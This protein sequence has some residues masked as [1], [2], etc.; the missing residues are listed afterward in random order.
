MRSFIGVEAKRKSAWRV[1]GMLLLVAAL[2][3]LNG[4]CS[5][6]PST[7]TPPEIMYFGS[8]ATSG[9]SLDGSTVSGTITVYVDARNSYTSAAFFVD[10]V[11]MKGSPA[12]VDNASPYQMVLDTTTLADGTNTLTVDVTIGNGGNKTKVVTQASF[13]VS[14]TGSGTNAAPVVDAGPDRSIVLGA[15]VSLDGKVS[16]DGLPSGQ[17]TVTWSKVTGP[18]SVAFADAASAATTATFSA[19]GTYTLRLT[20]DD[21][22]LTGTD[23]VVVTVSA[24]TT[25]G[26][27][28][29]TRVQT[30]FYPWYGTPSVDG[31]WIHWEQNGHSPPDDIASQ[32]YPASG[33]YSDGDSATL[34]QQMKWMADAGIGVAIESWWGQGSLEDQRTPAVLAAAAANGVKVAFHIEPYAGRTPTSVEADIAYLYSHYGSSPAFFRVSRATTYGP[35]TSPRGVFYVF[36]PLSS[37]TLAKWQAAMDDLHGSANDAFV[38]SQHVSYDPITDGHFDGVYTYDALKVDPSTFSSMA[39]VVAGSGGVFAPSVGPGYDDRRARTNGAGHVSRSNGQRYDT[40][41]QDAIA[42]GAPWVTITSFN[43]WHEGTQIEP[44][45]SKAIAGFTYDDYVGAYGATAADAPM[46]YLNRTRYWVDTFLN[47]APPAVSVSISPTSASL[48][49]GGSTSFSATVSNASDTSVTWST[50]GGSVSGTGN[51]VTYTAPGSAGTYHVTA[52]S[53]QDGSKTATATVTVTAPTTSGVPRPD[54]VLVVIE[55]NHAYSDIYGSSAAPYLN[56]LASGGALFTQSYAIEHPSEP[57]YLD[58]FSGSN[59]GVTDDSCPH[60]FTTP[61][62]GDALLGAGFTFGAYSEDL[63]SVGSTVCTN[64]KY[65]RKHDP[66]VNWAS[67]PGGTQMPFTSFPTDYT[68]LPDVSFVIPNLDNDMHDGSVSQGDTWLKNNI[69]GYAQW[70]LTHNSLLI[71]TFD[72]GSGSNQIFTVFYGQNVTPGTYAEHVDH[73]D[74]LRTLLD[75][76]ALSPM[77]AAVSAT[78]VTDVWK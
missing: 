16:D 37:G 54:H 57:N 56:S 27:S 19:V 2:A 15:G 69:G 28:V 76:Y 52:T 13:T 70:A 5:T 38:V 61:N 17:L 36:D 60:S 46:A 45:K 8:Q 51:T 20:A 44:A 40:F 4:G 11:Q 53:N 47:Q 65:A 55:E 75:M 22:A 31:N 39:S 6:V 21:G 34:D 14:N 26:G 23:D 63:P 29:S 77:G 35:S 74:M 24:G 18:G 1:I 7:A 68:T 58:L 9:A 3:A 67:I 32:F 49:T 78:P 41:W 64:Q 33:P 66:W 10:D 50:D 62:L 25:S 71:V 42:S 48:V 73:F 12:L 72:E 59:Q 43:E 30:F